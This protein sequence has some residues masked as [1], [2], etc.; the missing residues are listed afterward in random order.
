MTSEIVEL[1]YADILKYVCVQKMSGGVVRDG[2][3]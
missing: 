1:C 2:M 3:M